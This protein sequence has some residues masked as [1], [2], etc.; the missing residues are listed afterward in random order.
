MAQVR[1][2]APA[3]GVAAGCEHQL[4]GLQLFQHP[5]PSPQG[6]PKAPRRQGLCSLE[7]HRRAQ[8]YPRGQGGVAQAGRH[9]TGPVTGGEQAAV[10]FFHQ[11]EAPL[12]KP[13]H[14]VAGS[15]AAEGPEQGLSPPR[16][17]AHQA[18]GVPVGMGDI[19]AATATD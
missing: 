5:S 2:Q 11:G 4:A 17:M 3:T 18:A 13:G 1:R 6:Q 14:R 10:I 12:G 19:A 9:R 15:K 8:G 16:V 7:G